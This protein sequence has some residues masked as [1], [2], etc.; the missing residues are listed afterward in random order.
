MNKQF[1]Q[2]LIVFA[3]TCMV[4]CS[5]MLASDQSEAVNALTSSSHAL[6][7]AVESV[8]LDDINDSAV[9]AN[10]HVRR[11]KVAL[12]DLPKYMDSMVVADTVWQV[13]F[14]DVD[15]SKVARH[16][17][18]HNLKRS[19]SVLLDGESGFLLKIISLPMNRLEEHGSL[20]STRHVEHSYFARIDFRGLPRKIEVDF[21]TMVSK[22]PFSPHVAEKIT[23]MYVLDS[24]SVSGTPSPIWITSLVGVPPIPV[25][26]P[27]REH[28]PV[29]DN[30]RNTNVLVVSDGASG[31]PLR[32]GT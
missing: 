25:S 5:N 16:E 12:N 7:R 24:S 22:C 19:I 9:I 4:H 29:P 11:T 18:V 6:A 30:L 10:A 8:G 31:E 1:R 27:G 26:G 23:S 2:G 13:D 15:F 3:V 14:S 28:G 17:I 21:L 20:D 32:A